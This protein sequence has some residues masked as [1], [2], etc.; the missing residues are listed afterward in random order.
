LKHWRDGKGGEVEP[1]SVEIE[2]ASGK[3]RGA[4][5]NGVEA[6]RGIPYAA[7]P[8]G[9]FRFQPPMPAAKWAGVRHAVAPGPVCPQTPSRLRYAMGDF[10]ARQDEDCLQVTVWTP[11]SGGGARPV[12]VWLHGGAYMSGAGAIDWYSGETLAREGGLVV[13]GVNYR[14]GA[15]GF[16]R[17][18]DWSAGNLG[19]LDQQAALAWVRDNIAAFGGDPGNVTLWGQSAGAQSATF[20]LA[21]PE[22]RG[23]FRRVILQSP[24]FGSL[25]RP[26]E[27]AVAIAE[28]IARELGFDAGVATGQKLAD[29]PLEKLFAAQAAVGA[30]VA[31]DTQRGGLPS[32]PFWPVGDGAVVPTRNG[33]AAAMT[34]AAQHLD[35]MIGTTREEMGI[36]FASNPAMQ[37]LEQAPIPASDNAR[38]KARRP[39][40][41][42]AALYGDY[43]T[44]QIFGNGSIEWAVN[45]ANAGR[46]AYLY[47][48]DWPS[49]DRKLGSCHCLDLPFAFGTRAAFADAA[50]L[51]GADTGDIDALSAVM[52]ASLIAFARDGDPNHAQLPPWP[53]FDARRRATMHFDTVCAAYGDA[54]P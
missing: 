11:Q 40:A 33:Y 26:P 20:L 1:V 15:L 7:A 50:M 5:R 36:F 41:S 35:V 9:K 43:S 14:V 37:N 4:R 48:F 17:H 25:P 52:R 54:G 18:P 16:L 47:Q 49:P 3:L 28:N 51:A 6:F 39:A 13:V 42:A 27:A 32:P 29:V 8:T 2:I 19:L 53:R 34:D 24:P 31:K 46:R 22:T 23:L 30:Q 21:R 44:E 10:T 38:L 45:A 12:L